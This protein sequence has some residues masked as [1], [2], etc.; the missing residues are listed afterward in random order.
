MKQNSAIVSYFPMLFRLFWATS[1]YLYG[2]QLLAQNTDVP[3]ELIPE[4]GKCYGKAFSPDE[5]E[6]YEKEVLVKK[7]YTK[8]ISIPAVYDTISEQVLMKEGYT[9]YIAVPPVYEIIT[10]R[11]LVKEESP[12][13]NETYTA[14]RQNV[15]TSSEHGEW[16][17]KKD[18]TCFAPNPEDCYIMVWEKIPD[19]YE[20]VEEKVLKQM[21]NS[22]QT[23]QTAQ[24]KTISK[25]MLKTPATVREVYH[26]PVYTTI[27][28][29]VLVSPA[30]SETIEVPDEYKK[31]TDRR[32]VKAGG[33][34]VWVEV[35][36]PNKVNKTLIRTI[37]TQLN[38]KGYPL[39]IDGIWGVATTRALTQFQQSNGIASG[40]LNLQTL[41]ALY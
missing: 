21:Q 7:A 27:K 8:T 1:F 30:K 5:Y 39:A 4:Y 26:E 29:S 31:V 11:V 23:A 24:Y 6:N 28:K 17:R 3:N 9:E 38:H 25:R 22:L 13:I 10:E 35:L 37:Q 12:L 18:P 32:L 19:Q 15:K 14:S 34:P 20:V 40:N 16:K 33:D 41:Q 36:C 2:H